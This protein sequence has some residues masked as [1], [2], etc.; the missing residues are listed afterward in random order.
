MS[1]WQKQLWCDQSGESDV[2][3]LDALTFEFYHQNMPDGW[4]LLMHAV[5]ENRVNCVREL[6][7]RPVSN[8]YAS[9]DTAGEAPQGWFITPSGERI[10]GDGVTALDIARLMSWHMP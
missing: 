8:P 3:E 4:T 6:L 5:H 7:Q 2:K 1:K 9:A 10:K